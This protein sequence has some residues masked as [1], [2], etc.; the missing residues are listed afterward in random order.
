MVVIVTGTF[1]SSFG[2]LPVIDELTIRVTKL[3]PPVAIVSISSV[4][5]LHRRLF[6]HT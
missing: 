3:V 2:R 4:I 5:A 6:E 1:S